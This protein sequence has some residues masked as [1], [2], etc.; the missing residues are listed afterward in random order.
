MDIDSVRFW[1]GRVAPPIHHLS[2]QLSSLQALQRLE[3][4]GPCYILEQGEE[5]QLRGLQ[6]LPAY[7]QLRSLEVSYLWLED[8]AWARVSGGSTTLPAC[9]PACLLPRPRACPRPS[10]PGAR[11]AEPLGPSPSLC[12]ACGC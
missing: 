10:L 11:P 3:I 1:R 9:L 8:L 4:C 7:R 12:C 5:V 6:V 2:G